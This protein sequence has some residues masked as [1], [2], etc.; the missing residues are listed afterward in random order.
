MAL[1]SKSH[2]DTIKISLKFPNDPKVRQ[3]YDYTLKIKNLAGDI[4]KKEHIYGLNWRT[5]IAV[6]N[7]ITFFT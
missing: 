5:E 2:E 1:Y 7:C 4:I 3:I 6:P